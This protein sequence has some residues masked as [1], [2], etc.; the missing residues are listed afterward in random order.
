MMQ[1]IVRSL[2]T[3]NIGNALFMGD[4]KGVAR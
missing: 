3:M 4:E 2:N 1:K